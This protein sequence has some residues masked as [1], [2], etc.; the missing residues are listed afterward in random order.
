MAGG[1]HRRG[2]EQADAAVR[3]DGVRGGGEF[4]CGPTDG[5]DEQL[6]A[7]RTRLEERARRHPQFDAGDPLG[8]PGAFADVDPRRHVVHGLADGPATRWR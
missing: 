8:Q 2:G 3:I 7:L 1:R 5:A 6:G 4:G